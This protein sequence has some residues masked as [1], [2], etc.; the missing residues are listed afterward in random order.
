MS[1]DEPAIL[2]QATQLARECAHRAADYDR[3][4][5][6]PAANLEA[7]RRAGFFR[8]TLPAA[9]GGLGADLATAARVLRL[10]G[11]GDASTALV[12]TQHLAVVG[13]FAWLGSPRCQQFLR[14][15]VAHD[16]FV[17]L[18]A[19]APEFEGRAPTVAS[20]DPA[21]SG[22]RLVGRKG[23]ASGCR[24]AAWAVVPALAQGADG[25]RESLTCLVRLGSAGV[26]VVESWDT[27]G[28]RAS[29]SH[30]VV[31]AE[32]FV[33]DEDVI[34]RVPEV[35]AGPR[36]GGQNLATGFFSFGLAFFADRHY[37]TQ[38]GQIMG[39]AAY[40]SPE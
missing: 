19:G 36:P 21:A 5:Q 39:S 1:T 6:F 23:F 13:A 29:E 9:L 33:P 30:D 38:P 14:E 27:V 17:G 35:E 20:R 31:F 4:G 3:S 25:T 40:L 11:A 18:F 34:A 37:L 7:V 10:L 22:W 15:E 2:A 24:I 16:R 26:Q 28:L 12:L 32:C 8:L